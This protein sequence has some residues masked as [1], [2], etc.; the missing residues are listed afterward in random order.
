MET[1]LEVYKRTI[2]EIDLKDFK[3]YCVG[4]NW[5]L[6]FSPNGKSISFESYP[7]SN[8]IS[9]YLD[10]HHQTKKSVI[11]SVEESL[12]LIINYDDEGNE[13]YIYENLDGDYVIDV[14]ED[15]I[16]STLI[17]NWKQLEIGDIDRIITS[18]SDFTI[19]YDVYNNYYTTSSISNLSQFFKEIKESGYDYNFTYINLN[20]ENDTVYNNFDYDEYCSIVEDGGDICINII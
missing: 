5:W 10:E 7:S 8:S 18:G 12:E 13:K 9:V 6:D 2:K 20:T 19:V 17:P 4:R 15:D 11:E 1:K 16:N 3:G 14:T